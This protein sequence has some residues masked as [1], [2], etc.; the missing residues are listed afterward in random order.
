MRILC[1]GDSNTYGFDPRGFFGG[2]YGEDC[3]WPEVL[4]A[5][6]GHDVINEGQNGRT[7]PRRERDVA[8]FCDTLKNSAP[9]L[10]IIMLGT[11]DLLT[12][13]APED[14]LCPMEKLLGCAPDGIKVLLVAPPAITRGEW[15]SDERIIQGI[16]SM[17][18]L[19]RELAERNGILFLEA[20]TLPL[21]HDG[22]HLSEEGNRQLGQRLWDFLRETANWEEI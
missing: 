6:S 16:H 20:G 18:E 5:L 22:V 1:F 11:N 12:G 7:V 21:S 4:G 9:D 14:A 13:C 8:L 2:R 17:A 19:Y 10:L 15:V 3:R